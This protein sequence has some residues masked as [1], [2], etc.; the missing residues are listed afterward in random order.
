MRDSKTL[1]QWSVIEYKAAEAYLEESAS[2]ERQY[3]AM[4]KTCDAA[5]HQAVDLG[6]PEEIALE[7]WEEGM[8]RAIPVFQ[9]IEEALEKAKYHKNRGLKFKNDWSKQLKRDLRVRFSG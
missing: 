8:A 6:I 2:A 5:Y 4:Q 9:N 3:N 7:T 1:Y